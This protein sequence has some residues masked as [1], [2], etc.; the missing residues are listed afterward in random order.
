MA[1]ET[2]TTIANAAARPTPSDGMIRY[3]QDIQSCI[4]YDSGAS[5]WK[6]FTPDD[7]PYD[8]DGTNILSTTPGFLFDAT[9]I[10]G[11]STAA[12]DNPV[13]AQVFDGTTDSDNPT[14]G[15][16]TSRTNGVTTIVQGT[17]SKQPT[18]YTSGVNSKPYFATA[19]DYLKVLPYNKETY[20]ASGPFTIFGVCEQTAGSYNVNLGGQ[21]SIAQSVWF[22]LTNDEDLLF[23][24][25]TGMDRNA[26][27]P[28]MASGSGNTG[29]ATAELDV[30]RMFLVIRDS[31]DNTKVYY[32][33][34]NSTAAL[35][36]TY[37]G[38]ISWP[39]L[40]GGGGGTAYATTGNYYECAFFN[41]D[42]S[43]ADR[44]KLIT[45]VNTKYGSGRNADDTDDLA[46]LAF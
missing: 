32:D 44:N 29:T 12:G 34:D 26:G 23:Y 45:Y 1:Y 36:G 5:A 40:M 46:R 22:N 3:Q 39:A 33:G 10:D 31:S 11:A 37:T 42:L 24:N 21:S 18:Y 13:N 17:A 6:V 8:I 7:A 35:T 2:I 41:S 38:E 19:I 25:A 28:V 9:M 27:G 16:W 43:T 4:V 30:L 15:V 14:G 20:V